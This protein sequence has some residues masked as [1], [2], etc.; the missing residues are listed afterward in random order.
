ML[1]FITDIG[2]DRYR[3]AV[4]NPAMTHVSLLDVP[5]SSYTRELYNHRSI[6]VI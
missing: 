2:T 6:G 1:N 5:L 4:E 3:L